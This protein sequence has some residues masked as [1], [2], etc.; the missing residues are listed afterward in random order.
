MAVDYF[1]KLDTIPGG[2]TDK[3]HKDEIQI[4][5]FSWGA[6]NAGGARAG[7]GGGGA[8][9]VQLND[10]SVTMAASVASPKLFVACASGTHLKT[11]TLTARKAGEKP[12]DFLVLKFTDV[13]VT[14]YQAA[15]SAGG[16]TL[17]DGATLGYAK[18]EVEFRPQKP[19]GSPGAAVKGGWDV[20]KNK[21]A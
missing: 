13:L 2:S 15:G 12:H 4:E 6:T 19:D 14:S 21:P 10:L 7:A 5:G 17:V 9:K 16:D 3:A 1:L 20:A 8:G 11:A 18:V